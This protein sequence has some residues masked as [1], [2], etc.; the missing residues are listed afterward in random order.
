MM[1]TVQKTKSTLVWPSMG[2]SLP[3]DVFTTTETI[4]RSDRCDACSAAAYVR[5]VKEDMSLLFCGHHARKNL[6]SILEQ[7]WK[8]DDQTNDFSK[9][10]NA[11]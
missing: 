2:I 4:T 11:T 6:T 8:I 7:G 3:S 5:A 9:N 10:D 1:N